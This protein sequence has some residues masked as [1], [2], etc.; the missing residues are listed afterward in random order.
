[1]GEKGLEARKPE[2]L[3]AAQ[4]VAEEGLQYTNFLN[5]GAG[6]GLQLLPP[7]VHVTKPDGGITVSAKYGLLS[8]ASKLQVF[9]KYH[10][11]QRVVVMQ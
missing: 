7:A 11:V 8:D 4:S 2:K 1:M 9:I 3:A 5:V 6:D 10:S